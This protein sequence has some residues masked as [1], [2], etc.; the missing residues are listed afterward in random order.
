MDNDTA[1]LI[2]KFRKDPASA[3]SLLQTG[4]GKRL[5]QMLTGQDGGA[6]LERA[7]QSAVRGDTKAL[8]AMLTGLMKSP[9]GMETM[10]RISERAKK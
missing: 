2:E 10:R 4:D 6:S 3:Q 1:R 9:E 5:L 8:S 7:A